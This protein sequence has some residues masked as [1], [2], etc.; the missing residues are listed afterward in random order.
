MG[1]TISLAEAERLVWQHDAPARGLEEVALAA[2]LGRRLARDYD[3]PTP[4]PTTDRSA[5]DGFA[6]RAGHSGQ[7]AGTELDVVG[8]A[9]AGHPFAGEVGPGQ[10]VRIMTGAVVPAGADAVV[11]VEHTS[12]YAGA[13]A[14][15]R[16]GVRQGDHVRRRGSEVA[17][18]ERLL[19]AGQRVRSAEIGVL[20]VLGV[21]RVEVYRRPV[22]AIVSTG[23]EVVPIEREPAPHQ[24]R[25]SNSFALAAQV[26]ESGGEASRLGI[27][28]DARAP[29]SALLERALAAADVVLTIG[30]V[31]AGT[32]DLVHECLRELGVEGVFHGIALKPGKPTFFG[33]R[34]GGRGTF[35]FGLPGNPAS[36]YTVFDLL[37][38]P[39]LARLCGAPPL[40]PLRPDAL[41]RGAPFRHN[42]RLQAIPARLALAAAEIVAELRP[43]RPSGDPFGLTDADGYALVPEGADP[44]GARTAPFHPYGAGVLRP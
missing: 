38:R 21:A 10:A 30:G 33:V 23:D 3:S 22:V 7:P 20:A 5:M 9:L 34:R 4:W 18:G 8:E 25:D 26:E 44:G 6:L 29:L 43:V 32:H 37:V 28:P 41:V 36:C 16:Q 42:A 35:V 15:L 14:V 24:V 17:P 40:P 1:R 12:G 11:P 39:L 13:R 19:A 2:S 27:A 31:S